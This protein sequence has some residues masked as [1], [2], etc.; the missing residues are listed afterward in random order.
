MTRGPGARLEVDLAACLC[1][2]GEVTC[3]LEPKAPNPRN[4]ESGVNLLLIEVNA[5]T[6]RVSMSFGESGFE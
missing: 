1:R 4:V 3:V 5:W 2:W 6:R